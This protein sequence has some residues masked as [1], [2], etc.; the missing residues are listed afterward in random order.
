MSGTKKKKM[1]L[2]AS[3]AKAVLVMAAAGLLASGA[4]VTSNAGEDR[5][6][7]EASYQDIASLPSLLLNVSMNSAITG[8]GAAAGGVPNGLVDAPGMKA[9]YEE[10]GFKQFWTAGD[11]SL[12]RAHRVLDV[13]ENSWQHGLNPG[14]YHIRPIA[15]LLRQG[16][17]GAH[18]IEL[19]LYI[20]DAVIRY[21]Q[22]LTGMRV[23]P[24]NIRQKAKYWRQ[25]LRGYEI[26]EKTAL[27][28]DPAYEME[29]LAPQSLLYGRLRDELVRIS[30]EAAQNQGQDTTPV[31]FNG[32]LLKPGDIDR[33][34]PALRAR[35]G[36]VHDPVHGPETKYDDPLASAV[37]SFQKHH[38]LEPDAVIGSKTLS[39]LNRTT[40][41]RIR[42]IVANLERLRWLEQERPEKYIIVNIPSATLWAVK[43]DKVK[44]EMP[45]VVGMSYRPTKSFK[46]EITGI[47]LNPTWTVPQRLKW[48]DI[49]PKVREDLSYL[50]DKNI[51]L[52]NGFGPN[53]RTIDP[54]SVDWHNISWGEL[55]RIRMVQAPGDHNALGRYRVLMD[56]PY[57]I[58]MHDTNHKELFDRTERLNSS[59]CIRLERPQEIAHFIMEGSGNWSDEKMR[60]V[61]ETVKMT[62]IRTDKSFPVYILYQTIWL[63]QNG[64]LVYGR[65]VYKQDEKLIRTLADKGEYSLASITDRNEGHSKN[66]DGSP[67]AFSR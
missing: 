60:N 37:M 52:Y 12:Q 38:G 51:E 54:H 14:N 63:D 2:T 16:R 26:L 17:S 44:I 13:L 21:G 35:I 53:A 41:D 48:E 22:D 58:F 42:Q 4:P 29:A 66:H 9:F 36:L 33:N 62:D 67:L 57:D 7:F 1:F 28:D 40:E 45:V 11:E 15:R 20:S 5:I 24:D 46:T 31:S 39:V 49:L 61:L 30:A 18:D 65:D 25:P 64:T 59:G 56:N 43:N 55:G 27:S 10:R 34:V 47:R 8:D 6:V 50:D 19:E 23:D 3:S 32:R